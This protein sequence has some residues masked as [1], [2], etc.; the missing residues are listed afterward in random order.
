MKISIKKH[1]SNFIFSLG[2]SFSASKKYFCLSL[3]ITAIN[4][5]LPFIL[6]IL[7]RNLLNAL[8]YYARSV[9]VTSVLRIIALYTVLYFP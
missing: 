3:L 6:I 2:L 1:V 8:V 7:L 9:E 5:F 4:A